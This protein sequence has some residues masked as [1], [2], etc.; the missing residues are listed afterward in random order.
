MARLVPNS[1]MGDLDWFPAPGSQFCSL[2]G[3]WYSLGAWG[4]LRNKA[5]DCPF[6]NKN[7]KIESCSQNTEGVIFLNVHLIVWTPPLKVL[8]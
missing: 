7:N 5:L 3:Y 1:Y 8:Y 6:F 4:H 2:A